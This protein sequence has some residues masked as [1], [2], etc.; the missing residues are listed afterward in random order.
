[1]I[2]SLRIKNFKSIKE[3][4]IQLG[5]LTVLSGMNSSGKSTVIQGIRLLE[6]FNH[7]K[8]PVMLPGTVDM[9]HMAH[10]PSEPVCFECVR[11]AGTHQMQTRYMSLASELKSE[12]IAGTTSSWPNPV[13]DEGFPNCVFIGA[14]R[15]GPQN[16]CSATATSGP[17]HDFGERCEYV[18]E[19]IERFGDCPVVPA[20]RHPHAGGDTLSCNITGWLQGIAPSTGFRISKS[21]RRYG[22]STDDFDGHAP[23]SIGLGLSCVLP[24]IVAALGITIPCSDP[25]MYPVLVIENPKAFLH[26]Q[27]QTKIAELIALATK[28]GMQIVVKTHSEYFIDG[29]RL[30][31]KEKQID[32]KDV[33]LHYFTKNEEQSTTVESPV[34]DENGKLS[35]WPEGFGDQM[36]INRARLARR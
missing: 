18:Y 26:P 34:L 8:T 35:F 25:A 32:C 36:M 10:I 14:D 12:D 22:T 20:V 5:K 1:M 30:A 7:K 23:I 29:I 15:L 27:G 6:R 16:L 11:M 24:V 33:A 28:N 3:L 19:F 17:L 4:N 31:V 2:T 13:C 9:R 21:D